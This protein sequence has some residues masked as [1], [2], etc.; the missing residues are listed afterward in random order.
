MNKY[1]KIRVKVL[2][3]DLF[4]CRICGQHTNAPPH[5]IIYKS[6][7]GIDDE[8][9]MITLCNHHHILVHANE[10]LWKDILLNKQYE[11]YGYFD[12][13]EVKKHDKYE[14]FKFRK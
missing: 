9:N 5:H 1:Q 8:R 3:R 11:I 10:K 2:E 14:N 7:S 4:N 12:I 13:R 6:H